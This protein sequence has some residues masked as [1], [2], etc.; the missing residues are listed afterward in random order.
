MNKVR[1]IAVVIVLLAAFFGAAPSAYAMDELD[2]SVGLKTL[3]LLDNKLGGNVPVALIYNPKLPASQAEANSLYKTIT[4][5]FQA[6]GGIKLSAVM[7]STEDLSKLTTIKVGIVTEGSCTAAVA[8][9]TAGQGILTMTS[10]LDCVRA[11]RCVLGIK[12]RP[13]VEIFLS[14]SAAEAAKVG[15]S[16]AF[17][18]IAER[19]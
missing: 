15:F 19:V 7:V 3:P 16:Q 6:P 1:K 14:K 2:L 10:D 4:G 13:N 8:E 12:S 17:I 5:G 9:A 18:M 11:N